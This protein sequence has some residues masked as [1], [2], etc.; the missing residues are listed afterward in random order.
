MTSESARAFLETSEITPA[1]NRI[2]G[3]PKLQGRLGNK[4]WGLAFIILPKSEAEVVRR[5]RRMVSGKNQPA[6]Q[7]FKNK[8]L[9]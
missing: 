3:P 4:I 2:S 8:F 7:Y 9:I 6:C 5:V 1:Y